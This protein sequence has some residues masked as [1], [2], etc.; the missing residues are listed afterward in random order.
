MSCEVKAENGD[1]CPN[2]TGQV[3]YLCDLCLKAVLAGAYGP[4]NRIDAELSL[5]MVSSDAYV[6]HRKN[7]S[8]HLVVGC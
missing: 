4:R 1:H 6:T 5:G 2:P 7:Q 8:P 3:P